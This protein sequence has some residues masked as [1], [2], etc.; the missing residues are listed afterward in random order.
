MTFAMPSMTL[1]QHLLTLNPMGQAHVL[2]FLSDI[3]REGGQ[4]V[5]W[6][7]RLTIDCVWLSLEKIERPSDELLE[8][9][10][11]DRWQKPLGDCFRKAVEL[12][13]IPERLALPG[14]F[15][16]GQAVDRL[17]DLKRAVPRLIDGMASCFLLATS[18]NLSFRDRSRLKAWTDEARREL[19]HLRAEVSDLK[20]GVVRLQGWDPA[21]FGTALSEVGFALGR[22]DV[23]VLRKRTDE[24]EDL[25]QTILRAGRAFDP[26]FA[27][28]LEDK[29]SDPDFAGSE[30]EMSLRDV[31]GSFPN[32]PLPGGL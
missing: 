31:L 6:A 29:F 19:T 12:R 11:R 14:A 13:K 4:E 5:Y 10:S 20:R 23:G 16:Y 21:G 17:A 2:G 30:R 25:R 18:E 28:L 27:S 15:Q 26:H 3:W 8:E 1:V 32:W 24:K 7:E 9:I 22:F